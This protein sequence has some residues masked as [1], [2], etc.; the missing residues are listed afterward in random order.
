MKAITTTRRQKRGFTLIELVVVISILAI[1][2]AFALPRFAELSDEAHRASIQGTSGAYAAAV[3]LVRAQWT[4]RGAAGAQTDLPGFGEENVDVSADGWPT[5]VSGNTDPASITAE[6][7]R[8]L[9]LALMQ[10]NAPTV[11][12][13]GDTTDYTASASGSVC[14]YEYNLNGGTDNIQYDASN[15]E[16]IKVIN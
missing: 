14:T 5:G 13:S 6:E 10:S 12:I 4:A 15:G 2:A 3:A 1:L 8:D 11:A 16:V 9:W 7:C